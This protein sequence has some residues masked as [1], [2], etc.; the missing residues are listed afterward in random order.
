MELKH[1]PGGRFP[2]APDFITPFEEAKADK[3]YDVKVELNKG[4]LAPQPYSLLGD[5]DD[6]KLFREAW[7]KAF[8]ELGL[9]LTLDP[10]SGDGEKNDCMP[11]MREA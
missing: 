2:V 3:G 11:N 9:F 7:R 4:R 8:F 5:L 10:P 6:T 1:T